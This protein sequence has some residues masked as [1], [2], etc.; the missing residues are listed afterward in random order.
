MVLLIFLIFLSLLLTTHALCYCM[1]SAFLLQASV[2]EI[3]LYSTFVIWSIEVNIEVSSL[4]KSE[5]SS[6]IQFFGN[7]YIFPYTWQS[8]LMISCRRTCLLVSLGKLPY[9][10]I[11]GSLLLLTTSLG[12]NVSLWNISVVLHFAVW[13][14]ITLDHLK[15]AGKDSR[16][17]TTQVETKNKPL[18]GR[19]R[20]GYCRTWMLN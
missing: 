19:Q 12:K 5:C 1:T 16:A 7:F 15:C 3:T 4:H 2:N 8:N 14:W 9:I 20:R 6:V 18:L 13:I 10:A 11:R 17:N